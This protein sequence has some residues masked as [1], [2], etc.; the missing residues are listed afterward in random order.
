MTWATGSSPGPTGAVTF[1]TV[2]LGAVGSAGECS[3]LNI[4]V[5]DLFDGT[6]GDPQPISPSL[7]TDCTF[8]IGCRLEGDVNDDDV[9]DSADFQLIAQHIVWTTT[10][11]G[12][13]FLAAD[14]N[15]HGDVDAVDLQLMAQY[16]IHTITEF[17]GGTCIP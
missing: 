14:V 12:D 10:L 13:D 16:L 4:E 17:S 8:C 5:T 15:D 1:C 11:T 6:V 9:I 2:T 7:V 3:P